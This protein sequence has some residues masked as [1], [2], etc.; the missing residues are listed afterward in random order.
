MTQSLSVHEK[1]VTFGLVH[2]AHLNAHSWHK[3]IPKLEALGHNAIA[4]D[5]PIDQEGVNFNTY[6]ECIAAA[7][8][9]NDNLVIVG[10]SRMGKAISRVPA[11]IPVEGLIYLNAVI[12]PALDQKDKALRQPSTVTDTYAEGRIRIPSTPFF[13]YD[14]SRAM[15][16]FS[17]Y[18]PDDPLIEATQGD[19]DE[20]I[21]SLRRQ[22]RS[23]TAPAL[24]R[25]PNV[26]TSY[27]LATEDQVVKPEYSRY[28]AAEY[29]GV[30][31]V[32]IPGGHSPFLLRPSLLAQVLDSAVG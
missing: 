7:V 20:V 5:L 11:L 31:A 15:I 2:G 12:D 19:I 13:E 4:M 10:H 21:A 3:L 9:G 27:I 30:T 29:L 8:E 22:N 25:Q 17:D 16:F 1:P 24:A 23:D 26:K 28:V 14:R 6:A 32:E 18:N